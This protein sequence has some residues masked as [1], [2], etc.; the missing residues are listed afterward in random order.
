LKYGRLRRQTYA[1]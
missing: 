1:K